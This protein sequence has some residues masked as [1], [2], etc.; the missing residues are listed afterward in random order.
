MVRGRDGRELMPSLALTSTDPRF[1]AQL[2]P[3]GW[4]TWASR[5]KLTPFK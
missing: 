5:F 1:W 2:C 3:R 4:C